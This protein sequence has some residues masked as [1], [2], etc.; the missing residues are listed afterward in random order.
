MLDRKEVYVQR[1]KRVTD[2]IEPFSDRRGGGNSA[3]RNI[4]EGGGEG[5]QR[6][7]LNVYIILIQGTLSINSGYFPQTI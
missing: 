6:R 3:P 1:L 4:P 7:I 2:G 5:V